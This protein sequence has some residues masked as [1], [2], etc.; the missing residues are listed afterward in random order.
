MPLEL[1]LRPRRTRIA[2]YLAIED[3]A[4]NSLGPVR[5]RMLL[6]LAIESLNLWTQFCRSYAINCC[7]GAKSVNGFYW[8][9]PITKGWSRTDICIFL[10]KHF[11]RVPRPN[12]KNPLHEPAWR[13]ISV[14]ERCC[15]EMSI[16]NVS[17][18]Q[19][20]VSLS[21]SFL[22]ELHSVRNFAAHKCEDTRVKIEKVAR[23]RGHY[24]LC[25]L[26][27]VMLLPA[28]ASRGGSVTRQWLVEI[29]TVM[30]EMCR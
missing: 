8:F 9:S 16:Q 24:A 28:S 15:R 1:L 22:R 10:T 11:S 26:A 21:P 6:Y 12:H 2:R 3:T 30:V 19:R 25:D 17:S 7:R 5:D 27:E 13:D 29:D 14:I 18:V 20:A 23:G 4:R